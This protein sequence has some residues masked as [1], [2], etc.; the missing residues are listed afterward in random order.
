MKI[1]VCLFTLFLLSCSD[2]NDIH[3]LQS[4]SIGVALS[5]SSSSIHVNASSVYL[6]SE[7]GS[8]E[9]E[10]SSNSLQSSMT[11]IS[12][13]SHQVSSSNTLPLS[14]S[15]LRAIDSS[16]PV[17]S[18]NVKISSSSFSSD[19]ISSETLSSSSLTEYS[20]SYSVIGSGSIDFS[21]KYIEGDS[22]RIIALPEFG[23][24][25]T[26]WT[27]P[28][29]TLQDPQADTTYITAVKKLISL[30]ITAEFSKV[31]SGYFEAY[32]GNT[33]DH[34]YK[35][36]RIGGGNTGVDETLWMAENLNSGS[37]TSVDGMCYNNET[38]CSLYGKLY[39][40]GGATAACPSGWELPTDQHWL[41]LET[42]IGLTNQSLLMGE[43]V[44]RNQNDEYKKIKAPS[45]LWD[46]TLNDGEHGIG[47]NILPAGVCND[48]STA[49]CLFQGEVAYF[50]TA[51]QYPGM[52]EY[53]YLRAIGGTGDG[54]LRSANSSTPNKN[55]FSIR[56]V[57]AL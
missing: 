56:C 9:I 40:K 57:K 26:G 11:L 24:V 39:T 6:S 28:N 16:E 32:N 3:S 36:V 41:D 38:E 43:G 49:S 45:T 54:I 10:V 52:S 20:V 14:S 19:E 35:W 25:F 17:E 8:S 4:S 47:I 23:F 18:S 1:L 44:W 46:G 22:N 33:F 7:N 55:F 5:N 15:S 30:S 21:G 34:S 42:V 12:N 27:A 29:I 48:G 31:D 53:Y 13:G 51:T 37:H 2:S 50:W